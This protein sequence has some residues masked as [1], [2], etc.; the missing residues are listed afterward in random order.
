MAVAFFSTTAPQLK[1]GRGVTRG[2]LLPLSLVLN[3]MPT[4][5]SYSSPPLHLAVEKRGGGKEG[6]NCAYQ[7]EVQL[8]RGEKFHPKLSLFP[9][10]RGKKESCCCLSVSSLF[11]VLLLLF[12]LLCP[13]RLI[14]KRPGK[15]KG[16]KTRSKQEAEVSGRNNGE[17]GRRQ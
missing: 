8:D 6:C 14:Y 5:M 12:L 2:G 10:D 15:E 7:K 16:E 9:S 17:G 1:E 3:S 11:L 4:D 13:Q